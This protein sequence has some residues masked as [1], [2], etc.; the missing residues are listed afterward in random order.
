MAKFNPNKIKAFQDF[1]VLQND[2]KNSQT[3]IEN[4]KAIEQ[5]TDIVFG[6]GLVAGAHA[7]K[8]YTRSRNRKLAI[9]GMLL[10]GG[11]YLYNNKK[12]EESSSRTGRGYI[13]YAL[14]SLTG[15]GHID[16]YSRRPKKPINHKDEEVQSYEK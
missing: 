12:K 11:A 3:S 4:V 9:V 6:M 5:V 7:Q 15:R 16:Y 10:A 13:D 1:L 8:M 14:Y 2:L